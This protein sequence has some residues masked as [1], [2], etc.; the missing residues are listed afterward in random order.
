M[1]VSGQ[2]TREF[3][4]LSPAHYRGSSLIVVSQLGMSS[5]AGS[6]VTVMATQT[7]HA[8][9][10]NYNCPDVSEET[11]TIEQLSSESV[12]P[13]LPP[14]TPFLRAINRVCLSGEVNKNF[15]KKLG[16]SPRLVVELPAVRLWDHRVDLLMPAPQPHFGDI[17]SGDS[18][19]AGNR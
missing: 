5:L 14:Q 12:F 11:P 9:M 3:V 13:I 6:A 1:I 4:K 15:R 10:T 17:A 8:Y 7:S 19:T 18:R 16:A 2:S